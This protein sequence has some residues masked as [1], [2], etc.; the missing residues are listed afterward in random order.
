MS[1]IGIYPIKNWML[2]VDIALIIPLL[3]W[4]GNCY[5]WWRQDKRWTIGKIIILPLLIPFLFV[6]YINWVHGSNYN[7]VNIGYPQDLETQIGALKSTF[8]CKSAKSGN[9]SKYSKYGCATCKGITE[10]DLY[11]TS[12]QTNCLSCKKGYIFTKYFTDC[13]GT[14][15]KESLINK[16]ISATWNAKKA[17]AGQNTLIEGYSEILSK[18]HIITYFLLLLGI[19]TTAKYINYKAFNDHIIRR[20]IFIVFLTNIIALCFSNFYDANY[21]SMFA[22]MPLSVLHSI[23]LSSFM[24][25]ILGYMKYNI[26]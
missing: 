1:N 2:Y 16:N 3:F 22:L 20:F 11:E 6:F 21:L 17:A 26:A 10:G 8:K 5:W 12:I 19:L 7:I 25:I 13:T 4:L 18:F 15:T 24:I 23:C 9:C 14:C